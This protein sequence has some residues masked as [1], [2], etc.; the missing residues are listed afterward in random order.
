MISSKKS[1][2]AMTAGLGLVLFSITGVS[3]SASASQT[4][5]GKRATIVSGASTIT[6]TQ[7]A[8]V[9]VA[10]G[11]KKH[12]IK[13]LGGNDRICSAK[14]SDTI[15]GGAGNDI[16]FAAAG[17]DTITGDSGNDVINGDA[18]N[19]SMVGGTGNDVLAGGLGDDSLDGGSGSDDLDGNDGADAYVGGAGVDVKHADGRD[20]DR[21]SEDSRDQHMDD[22]HLAIVDATVSAD[23][24][25]ALDYIKLGIDAGE[26]TGKGISDVLPVFPSV[27]AVPTTTTIK[28]VSWN[29]RQG[30]SPKLC[31]DA[32]IDGVKFSKVRLDSE[33]RGRDGNRI[34]SGTCEF[35]YVPV[36]QPSEISAAL[37]AAADYV[38]AGIISGEI[39]GSGDQA[40][41]P[42]T[43]ATLPDGALITRVKWGQKIE[44][45]VTEVKFFIEASVDGIQV[46]RIEGK[47]VAGVA[48]IENI[49][50]GKVGEA[51]EGNGGGNGGNGGNGGGND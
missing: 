40:T 31:V 16:I 7:G 22:S 14:G 17:N 3:T 33:E 13:G 36:V 28:H 8:D 30:K 34:T 51:H 15:S 5:G 39:T 50:D 21:D 18:G 11:S 47:V 44:D 49:K 2:I 24:K 43:T 38:G 25:A 42:V 46:F 23:L 48:T 45:S 10:T 1:L 20:R 29:I 26:L 41:L 37:S 27:A 32:S 6:G 19:D 4:C 9:I 12:K 35:E